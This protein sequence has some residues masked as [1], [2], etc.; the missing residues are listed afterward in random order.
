MSQIKRKPLPTEECPPED[1]KKDDLDSDLERVST[2]IHDPPPADV[3]PTRPETTTAHQMT[4]SSFT[5]KFNKRFPAH[6]RYIGMSRNIF[7]CVILGTIIV[8]LALVIGL[9]VGLTRG[10]KYDIPLP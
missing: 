8:L 1:L 3:N 4:R 7:L 5:E 9:S 2:E 6:R 10:S